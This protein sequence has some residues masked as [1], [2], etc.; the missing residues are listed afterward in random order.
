M[1]LIVQSIFLLLSLVRAALVWHFERSSQSIELFRVFRTA[2]D[3]T[4]PTTVV[5]ADQ[6]DAR[7]R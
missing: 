7:A 3:S 6:N 5:P 2:P 1:N 4:D